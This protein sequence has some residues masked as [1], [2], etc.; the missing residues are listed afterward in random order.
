MKEGQTATGTNRD[1]ESPRAGT[2]MEDSDRMIDR[3][4]KKLRHQ[5]TNKLR[6][7]HDTEEGYFFTSLE[8]L[9]LA[10]QDRPLLPTTSSERNI[11]KILQI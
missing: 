11:S 4:T 5:G 3:G 7:Q 8:T 9:L 6:Q 1:R 10:P 2:G